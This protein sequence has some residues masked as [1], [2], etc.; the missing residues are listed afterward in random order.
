MSLLVLMA[1]LVTV[2]VCW[3]VGLLLFTMETEM[4]VLGD[5]MSEMVVSMPPV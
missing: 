4:L 2:R 1:E 5:P 3:M